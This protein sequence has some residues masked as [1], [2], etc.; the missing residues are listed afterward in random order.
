MSAAISLAQRNFDVIVFYKDVAGS[1][2]LNLGETL[3]RSVTPSL[4]ELGV[5]SSFRKLNFEPIEGS[6]SSWGTPQ[7]EKTS[8][9]LHPLGISW[10]CQKDAFIQTLVERAINGGADFC[11]E[12]VKWA[13]RKGEGAWSIYRDGGPPVFADLLIVA[14]GRDSLG[15]VKLPRSALVDKL[16]ACVVVLEDRRGDSPNFVS[17]DASANGWFFSVKSDEKTRVLSYFTDGDLL[18]FRGR[19]ELL[20]L[21]NQQLPSLPSISKTIKQI[22]AAEGTSFSVVSANSAFRKRAFIKNLFCCGDTAQTFDPLSSQ[23]I[24]AAVKDGIETAN[25]IAGMGWDNKESLIEHE[26]RRRQRYV[27]YLKS[28]HHIYSVEKRWAANV[29][30]RRRQQLKY[31]KAFINTVC[32]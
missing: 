12:Q 24:S 6:I 23:G 20:H 32:D 26:R 19:R 11:R 10:V 5:F 30:W 7:A 31:I 13:E 25:C 14:T 4:A 15:F 3:S 16:V 8:A 28:R 17:L 27:E 22:D 21:L 18:P 1:A 2:K 9:L 29:F